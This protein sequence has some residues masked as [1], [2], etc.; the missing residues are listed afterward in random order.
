MI[1]PDDA[2]VQS[3]DVIP[4][5]DALVQSRDVILPDD[6]LQQTHIRQRISVA[7]ISPLPKA[8]LCQNGRKRKGQPAELIT[9]S[10]FKQAV[11]E[12]AMKAK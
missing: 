12:V 11:M 5:D 6:V 2:L 9:S 8:P 4:P 10:P 3:S 1:P 7:H